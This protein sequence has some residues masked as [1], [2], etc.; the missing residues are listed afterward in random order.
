MSLT[1]KLLLKILYHKLRNELKVGDWDE[2]FGRRKKFPLYLD[3]S[4]P[5]QDLFVAD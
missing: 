2:Y 4:K 3:M 1:F 5:S